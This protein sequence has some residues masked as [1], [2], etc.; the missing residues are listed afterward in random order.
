[1]NQIQIKDILRQQ[2]LDRDL[3]PGVGERGFICLRRGG[4]LDRCIEQMWFCQM[5]EAHV[6]HVDE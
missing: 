5:V 1:M 2:N 6:G 3:E 4:L